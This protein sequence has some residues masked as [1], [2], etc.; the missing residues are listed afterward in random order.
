MKD[1]NWRKA[2]NM[3]FDA[4]LKKS[5]MDWKADG[6]IDRYKAQLV[7]KGFH[8]Q[9]GI[10]YGETYNLVV[11]PF[12]ISLILSIAIS[13]GWPIHQ[14][15]IQNAFLHGRIYEAALIAGSDK[16]QKKEWLPPWLKWQTE[17]N[18]RVHEPIGSQTLMKSNAQ[19]RHEGQ[20]EAPQSHPALDDQPAAASSS[21]IALLLPLYDAGYT[22]IMAALSSIQYDVSSI[23]QEVSSIILR[24]EQCQLDI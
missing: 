1:P 15:D 20:G 16:K 24:V 18:M 5:D 21:Q 22:Q 23:Q 3:E 17:P 2:M 8:Q 11:K 6:S 13:G 14:I 7:V 12:T 19:L 9:A 4:V 10:D